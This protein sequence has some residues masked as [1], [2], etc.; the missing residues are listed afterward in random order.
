MKNLHFK[1]LGISFSILITVIC[2]IQ[3][4]FAQAG[5]MTIYYR[6]SGGYYLGE[7]IIFDGKD[8]VGNTTLLKISGPGLPTQGVPV[9][10]LN[11]ITGSGNTVPMNTDGSWKFVWL[12]ANIAGSDK[13]V[14][15]RY[16]IT[17][18]DPADPKNTASVSVFLKKPESYINPQLSPVK[19]GDYIQL[20]GVAEQGVTN[21]KI[22]ITDSG[23]K[24]LHTYTA[25]VSGSGYFSYEFRGIMQP[26]QYFVSASNP[27]MTTT[28]KSIIT[29]VPNELSL[30]STTPS[31]SSTPA[32]NVPVTASSS[33]GL[34]Q[35]V[36]PSPSA[37]P[38]SPLT[39]IAG[40]IFSLVF[41][42]LTI[43]KKEKYQ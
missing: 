29:V 40:L 8:T 31:P 17:A 4:V 39:V 41:T 6:G 33:P 42:G 28:L 9:Y 12:S 26:G 35:T 43:R 14:T 2:I 23:G 24:I 18:F 16:T 7:N 38:L 21:V 32:E 15:A 37:T 11:G 25:P 1:K 22:D 34:S 5:T 27:V 20:S 10:D 13:M 19:P 30:P 36:T 3:P